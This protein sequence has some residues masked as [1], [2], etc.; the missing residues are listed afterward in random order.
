MRTILVTYEN[1]KPIIGSS[2]IKRYAFNTDANVQE[3]DLIKS[4]KYDNKMKVEV[5]MDKQYTYFNVLNGDLSDEHNNSYQHPIRE[6]RIGEEDKD[7]IY[8][9]IV[10]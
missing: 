8:G 6:L 3:G 7:I 1:S 9:I 4:S 5:I 10:K 2:Y